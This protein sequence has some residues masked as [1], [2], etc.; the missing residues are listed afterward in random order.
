MGFTATSSFALPSP[1]LPPGMNRLP[2]R[3]IDE[4]THKFIVMHGDLRCFDAGQ[5]LWEPLAKQPHAL[6]FIKAGMADVRLISQPERT[7]MVF[8]P[9]DFFGEQTLL[10]GQPFAWD[11]V[12]TQCCE[13]LMLT[14][15]SAWAALERWPSLALSLM[16]LHAE[17]ASQLK[18]ASEQA[19]VAQFRPFALS[20]IDPLTGALNQTRAR[21]VFQRQIAREKRA[22]R[23]CAI[24]VFALE[25]L[26][27]VREHIGDSAAD[28]ALMH[29]FQSI[30][31][32]CRPGD[33]KS[34][35]SAIS[36][37]VLFGGADEA[38]ATRAMERVRAAFSG[39]TIIGSNG[40]PLPLIL[41]TQVIPMRDGELPEGIAC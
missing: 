6:G 39:K 34:R 5:R 37:A 10:H 14:E 35:N 22:G 24:G 23:A 4:E 8:G 28:D 16:K 30:D 25:N 9:G 15:R 18:T 21:S 36:L 7:L 41:R 19:I 1:F 2:A 27:L 20:A 13:V 31:E 26:D 29:L 40:L 17:R 32:Q 3:R 38:D 12:A 11:L 33:I